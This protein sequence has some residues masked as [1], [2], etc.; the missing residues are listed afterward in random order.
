MAVLSSSYEIVPELSVSMALKSLRSSSKLAGGAVKATTSSA[1]LCM[2]SA[3]MKSCSECSTSELRC[4][5]SAGV[6]AVAWL[7][8]ICLIHGSSSACLAVAR[9]LGSRCSSERTKSCAAA[10]TLPHASCSKEALPSLTSRLFSSRSEWWKG[11]RPLS[12]IYATTPRLHMSHAD[13]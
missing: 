6:V 7:A 11:R 1:T 3:C 9:D 12:S 10:E 4:I 8:H 2:A 5:S 13:V